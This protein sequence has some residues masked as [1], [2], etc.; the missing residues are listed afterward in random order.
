MDKIS[1]EGVVAVETSRSISEVDADEI[2]AGDVAKRSKSKCIFFPGLG[3]CR[4]PS[5]RTRK[6]IKPYINVCDPVPF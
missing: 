6:S 2:V 4:Q 1:C 3:C 5:F